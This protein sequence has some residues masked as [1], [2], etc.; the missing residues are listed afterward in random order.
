MKRCLEAESIDVVASR[1]KIN[2]EKMKR[3]LMA[4]S[5]DSAAT[6]RSNNNT[7][8]KRKQQGWQHNVNTTPPPRRRPKGQLGQKLIAGQQSQ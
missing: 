4:E 8:K 7:P 2:R 6:Q 5:H 3:H 1:K